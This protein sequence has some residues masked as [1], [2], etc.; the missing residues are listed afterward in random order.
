[1]SFPSALAERPRVLARVLEQVAAGN[2]RTRGLAEALDL[3]PRT[4]GA[5]LDAGA[6]LGLLDLDHEPGLTRAGLR[7]AYAGR[8]R[9]RTWAGIV[10]AHPFARRAAP[11]G[12]A[13]TVDS[14][15]RILQ[16]DA[17]DVPHSETRK[18]AVALRRLVGSAWTTRLREP[19]P[20]R[21]LS[22]PLAAA[23]PPTRRIDT[24]AGTEDS[25]DVYAVVL[26]ALL[27]SGELS[28]HHVR[29]LLDAAGGPQCG[30]GG[31]MAMAV[32]RGDAVRHGD[33]LVITDGALLRRELAESSISIALSDPDFRAHLTAVR[34]GR[35]GES[36]RFGP[37]MRR[38]FGEQ[39]LEAA[40]PG[41]LFGRTLDNLPVSGDP[42]VAPADA[43]GPFLSKLGTRG[44]ALAFPSS[45]SALTGGVAWVNTVLRMHAQQGPT[46]RPPSCLDRARVVHGG[47]LHPGEPPPRSVADMVAL[48]ARAIRNVPA[49]SLLCAVAVLERRGPLT[50]HRT[51]SDL[52]LEVA[53]R[54]LRLDSLLRTVARARDWSLVQPGGG[55]DWGML[56]DVA[57]SLGLLTRPAED[58]L[59][60]DEA[61]F[62]R[63]Q[64]DPEHR[65]LWEELA[66]LVELLDA[67]VARRAGL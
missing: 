9:A 54:P 50:L 64:T 35:P 67:S 22:L 51:P 62:R 37:W 43:P 18:R 66:P 65:E 48:R 57:V 3:E 32:R 56:A 12:Q 42:G 8:G 33:L 25:P 13:P 1:M 26:R 27:D 20:E 24:R 47:L 29:G 44:I 52:T 15:A 59:T 30:I 60:L 6:W 11:D 31:P 38:V 34:A 63:M 39:P 5:Y 45:L 10:R 58:R 36:R 21:Q 16:E 46:A 17:P 19:L 2:R 40:L 55:A 14:I 23:P 41:L 7:W 4:V 28:A 49:F 61:L 53:G